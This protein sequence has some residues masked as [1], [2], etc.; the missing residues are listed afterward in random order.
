MGGAGSPGDEVGRQCWPHVRW[1]VGTK[2]FP[3]S[4]TRPRIQKHFQESKTRP[5]KN[6][7]YFPESKKL[8]DSGTCF[9]F[10]SYVTHALGAPLPKANHHFLNSNN[11]EKN[12]SFI[13]VTSKLYLVHNYRGRKNNTTCKIYCIS[14]VGRSYFFSATASFPHNF[15][16][17]ALIYRI[18]IGLYDIFWDFCV[19]HNLKTGFSQKS[20]W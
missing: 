17:I 9:V 18:F 8:L 19:F 14:I 2:H 16:V 4:K 7:K 10:V 13:V 1:L 15:R 11:T 12:K 20:S 3:E 6:P 5:S